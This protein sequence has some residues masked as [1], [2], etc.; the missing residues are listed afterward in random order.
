M[1]GQMFLRTAWLILKHSKFYN[2]K[3]RKRILFQCRICLSSYY[4]IAQYTQECQQQKTLP[5]NRQY[6]G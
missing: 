5:R 4:A 1:K 3:K 2:F 6:S